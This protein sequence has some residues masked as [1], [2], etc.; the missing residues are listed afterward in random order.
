MPR[1]SFLL[2]IAATLVVSL[3]AHAQ[4]TVEGPLPQLAG[5]SAQTNTS[6]PAPVQTKQLDNDAIIKMTKAELGDNII[7]TA[8]RMQ[9]GTYMTAPDDLIALKSAGVSQAV[10]SAMLAR[11][12]GMQQRPSMF[13]TLQRVEITPLSPNTDDPGVYF[14]NK[15]GQ[16][17]MMGPELVRYRDGGALKSLVTNN[18]VKKDENGVVSGPSSKLS[19]SPGT[20]VLILSPN[21]QTDAV[22]YVILRLRPKSDRRE[23][24]VK[25]GNVFHAETGTDRDALEISIHKVN[26]RL[27]GFT[28]PHDLTKGEYGV[29]APWSAGG[30]GIGHAGKLYTFSITE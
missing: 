26:S 23:F 4:G 6:A 18:I 19:I 21:P 27:F 30:A 10:I 3:A 15:Q 13:P 8:V 28:V 29:L 12:S 1:L 20:E 22:E 2:T 24:R 5:K 25:T 14:K 16:W 7:V 9:P 17:E 11:N